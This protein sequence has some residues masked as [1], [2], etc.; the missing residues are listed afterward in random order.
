MRWA[1]KEVHVWLID[2]NHVN[3][4]VE[5]V[6]KYIESILRYRPFEIL[7]VS[8]ANNKAAYNSR[9]GM[10]NVF[11]GATQFLEQS[12]WVEYFSLGSVARK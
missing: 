12:K 6:H 2:R 5:S 3:T 4:M 7:L 9:R 1:T 11:N 8:C 10:D